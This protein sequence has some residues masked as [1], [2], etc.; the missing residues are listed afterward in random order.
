VYLKE[1]VVNGQIL[2]LKNDA[3]E[4]KINCAV[5][6]IFSGQ[7]GVP[8]VAIEFVNLVPDTGG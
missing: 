4:E 5:V 7:D 6:D 8:E 1:P 2:I 3:T